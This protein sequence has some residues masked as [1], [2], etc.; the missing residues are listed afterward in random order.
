MTLESSDE[1]Y[2]NIV[3]PVMLEMLDYEANQLAGET[4]NQFIKRMTSE[5]FNRW[6]RH[7]RFHKQKKDAEVIVEEDIFN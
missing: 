3:K 4:E 5:K 7:L 1:D 6:I 2:N